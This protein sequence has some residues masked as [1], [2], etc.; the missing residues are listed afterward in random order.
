MSNV[1]LFRFGHS[2]FIRFKIRIILQLDWLAVR[3]FLFQRDQFQEKFL[4]S[5]KYS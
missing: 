5:P 4:S 1:A 3:D 2:L